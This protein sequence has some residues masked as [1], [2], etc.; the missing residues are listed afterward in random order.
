MNT[1]FIRQRLTQIRCDKRISEYKM[2]YDMG[3]SKSYIQ[4]ITSGK[5]LPSLTEFLYMCDYLGVTP[6]EFFDEGIVHPDKVHTLTEIAS[7]LTEED[8]DA[9]IAV[10]E[11]FSKLHKAKEQKS[12]K[13]N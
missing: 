2:S 9:L 4:N 6:K 8:L 11:R 1:L 7:S 5:S 3:H 12:P 10:A 13:T